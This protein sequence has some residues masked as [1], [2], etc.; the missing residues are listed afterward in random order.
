MTRL[1][2]ALLLGLTFL[3]GGC[4]Q[5]PTS[6][7]S[8]AHKAF[9]PTDG[10]LKQAELL[11]LSSAVGALQGC[12]AL[13][14][15]GSPIVDDTFYRLAT[16][17]R[18]FMQSSD[19]AMHE[20]VNRAFGV[21]WISGQTHH[22]AKFTPKPVDDNGVDMAIEEQP[23]LD[24]ASCKTVETTLT[25]AREKGKTLDVL[26]AKPIAPPSGPVAPTKPGP[27]DL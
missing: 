23:V 14:I 24:E 1:I 22:Y 5:T 2:L 3:L 15:Y 16:Y 8:P 13:G 11:T 12:R 26:P 20:F 4:D 21:Y 18:A 25:K 27:N 10:Q 6:S 7:D 19:E 9:K 17:M